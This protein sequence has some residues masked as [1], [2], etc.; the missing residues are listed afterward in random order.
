MKQIYALAKVVI[1]WLGEAADRSN[2]VLE[3][4]RAADGTVAGAL[5]GRIFQHSNDS[6]LRRPWFRRIWV[7][8]KIRMSPF[9]SF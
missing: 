4:I 3:M 1:V 6:M 2:E 5:Y 9:C 8:N 7:K